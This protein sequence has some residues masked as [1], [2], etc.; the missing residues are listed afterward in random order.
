M[1]LLNKNKPLLI[2]ILG[3][4]I[5]NIITGCKKLV[6]VNPPDT[7]ITSEVVYNS[8]ATASSVLTGLYT[9]ISSASALSGDF[10]NLS[11]FGGLSADE[12]N[13]WNGSTDENFFRYYSNNLSSMQGSGFSPWE[14]VYV[15]IYTCNSAIE[16]IEA[17]SSLSQDV[18]KQLLGEAKFMRAL[19]YFYLVNLYD[20]IPLVTSTN[21]KVNERLHRSKKNEVYKQIISDL[22]DANV[23]LSDKYL[24]SDAIT[25]YAVGVE[26]RTRPTKWAATALLARVYLYMQDWLQGESRA[27]DII[28][29]TELFTLESLSNAFIKNNREAILQFQPVNSGWNTEDAKT[30]IIP[31]TGLS[32]NNPVYLSNSLINSFEE[33]DKR[34]EE[35]TNVYIDNNGNEF[36]YAYKFKSAQLNAPVTEYE[37]VLRLSE[38]YLIRAE[39]RTQLGKLTEA[40]QD[41][42][43]IRRR[44]GLKDTTASDKNTLLN[45]IYHERQVELFTEWA[46]RWLDLKR[47]HTIDSV[48]KIITPLKGGTWE[49]TDQLYPIPVNE[50]QRNPNLVQNIGY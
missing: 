25:P 24:K 32:N 4:L 43:A 50:L 38:Q 35:W 16:G 3:L 45:L 2:I 14:N 37:M 1:I 19:F 46:H 18:K 8:D 47:T 30:F 9:K 7:R 5:V 28:N 42:N 21:Y 40:L 20:D 12:L 11:F 23:F 6:E 48:M 34:K 15:Y 49:Q 44:A 10:Q 41:L 13:L 29:N 33:N 36:Y 22:E 39:A 26:E 27:S 17:S 31:S